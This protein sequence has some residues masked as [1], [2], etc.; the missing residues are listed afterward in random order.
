MNNNIMVGPVEYR[1]LERI[2]EALVRVDERI[3]RTLFGD[4]HGEEL[5]RAYDMVTCVPG[6][7]LSPDYTRVAYINGVACGICIAFH[8]KLKQPFT[9]YNFPLLE[10]GCPPCHEDVC[11]RYFDEVIDETKDGVTTIMAL[12]VLPDARRSG[13]GRALLRDALDGGRRRGNDYAVLDMI[14]DNVFAQQLYYSEGFRTYDSMDGYAPYRV[15]PP[16]VDR[17]VKLLV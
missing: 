1:Q 3:Y 2:A 12:A 13:A 4:M 5:A 7:P 8:G 9:W 16:R 11:E 15:K 17:M 10:F 14:E 6:S